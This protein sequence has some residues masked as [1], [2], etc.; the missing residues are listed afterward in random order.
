MLSSTSFISNVANSHIGDDVYNFNGNVAM[1]NDSRR[2]KTY[3]VVKTIS[4]PTMG[5]SGGL[6]NPPASGNKGGITVAPPAIA[7]PAAS[8]TVAMT[9]TSTNSSSPSILATYYGNAGI[10][11]LCAPIV[12]VCALLVCIASLTKYPAW[13]KRT[14]DYEMIGAQRSPQFKFTV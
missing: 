7:A 1:T 5:S 14:R 9:P 6:S 2:A 13:R 8:S 11:I 3:G 10:L 4:T 12:L